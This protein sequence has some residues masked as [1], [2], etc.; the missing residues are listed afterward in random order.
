MTETTLTKNDVPDLGDDTRFSAM[1]APNT[2][3]QV[4]AWTHKALLTQ[5]PRDEGVPPAFRNGIILGMR[6]AFTD[7]LPLAKS[8]GKDDLVQGMEAVLQLL[9]LAGVE[10]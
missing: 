10:G 9:E 2:R 5:E 6:D 8:A 3:D 4:R 7:A 1:I